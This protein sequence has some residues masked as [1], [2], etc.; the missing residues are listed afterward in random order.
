MKTYDPR[1]NTAYFAGTLISGYANETFIDVV[2]NVDRYTAIVGAD[3]E[4]ARARLNDRSALVTIT[5]L[6]TADSNAYL[7][8]KLLQDEIDD[9]GFGSFFLKDLNGAME[10]SADEAY[11]VKPADIGL[12]IEVGTRVWNIM[13]MEAIIRNG[14]GTDVL[15]P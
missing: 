2:Q 13:L 10:V 3:G 5:L 6:Q 9:N 8:S 7:D 11:I 14:G 15:A 4:F 12:D 1:K